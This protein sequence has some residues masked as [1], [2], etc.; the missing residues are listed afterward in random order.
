MLSVEKLMESI[1]SLV[2][3]ARLLDKTLPLFSRVHCFA[4]EVLNNSAFSLK[5]VIN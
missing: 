3:F 5:F 2:S 1:D 4:N